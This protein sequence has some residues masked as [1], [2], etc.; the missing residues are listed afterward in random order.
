MGCGSGEDEAEGEDVIISMMDGL[1]LRES[2]ADAALV[3]A[4]ATEQAAK[5]EL[6]R[7]ATA[8][9]EAER[10]V[11]R[12]REER[13]GEQENY[14]EDVELP[15]CAYC[16]W[17]RERAAKEDETRYWAGRRM[18]NKYPHPGGGEHVFMVPHPERCPK[19]D[20]GGARCELH[21]LHDGRCGYPFQERRLMEGGGA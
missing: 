2:A 11:L 3:V 18:C 7:A 6:C 21:H 16:G 15:G 14:A 17:T 8:R 10:A 20:S 9:V 5:T 19:R 1:A 13:A 12:L 4:R